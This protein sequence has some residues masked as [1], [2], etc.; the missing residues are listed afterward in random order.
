[1]RCTLRRVGEYGV[2]MSVPV[3]AAI[4]AGS[5]VLALPI[6]AASQLLVAGAQASN[7]A[8]AAALAAADTFVGLVSGGTSEEPCELAYRIA[9]EN[10]AELGECAVG[11]GVAEVRV[12]ARSRVGLFAVERH[13]RAGPPE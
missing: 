10:R 5:V 2:D 7:A 8:D 11:P 6:L 1:M 13:A 9:A 12:T 4:A 3:A